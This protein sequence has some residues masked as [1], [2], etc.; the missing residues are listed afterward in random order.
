MAAPPTG[1]AI[2]SFVDGYSH[3]INI[4]FFNAGDSPFGFQNYLFKRVWHIP[5][6]EDTQKV[7]HL[8]I[9]MIKNFVVFLSK[10]KY[11][12]CTNLISITI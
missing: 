12:I 9:F 10:S 11:V 5:P 2:M 3:S 4:Y 1:V 8:S 6:M 7:F